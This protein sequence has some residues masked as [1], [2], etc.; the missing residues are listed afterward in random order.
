MATGCVNLPLDNVDGTPSV[1]RELIRQEQGA[2]FYSESDLTDGVW[3]EF[4]DPNG[5]SQTIGGYL[6]QPEN[7]RKSLILALD[8]ASTFDPSGGTYNARDFHETFCTSFRD[9][10]FSTWSLVSTECGTAYGQEDLAELLATI[11]WLGTVG[12]ELLDIERV[13]CIGYSTGG[14]LAILASRQRTLSGAISIGGYTQAN[15]FTDNYFLYQIIAALFPNNVGACQLGA[16]LAFYGPPDSPAWDTLDSV[17]HINELQN[18]LL[19]IHGT[20]DA[21]SEPENAYAMQR[22]YDTGLA[23]GEDLVPLSFLFIEGGDHFVAR[24]D[25]GIRQIMIDYLQGFEPDT[26]EPD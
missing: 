25:V 23:A 6:G 11:D 20:A 16:T 8:G 15:Q 26:N 2:S 10:G 12:C 17:S 1:Q 24:H 4:E 9:A 18:P 22:R 7:G 21:I 14:T 13:Y 3:L 19:F 5:T